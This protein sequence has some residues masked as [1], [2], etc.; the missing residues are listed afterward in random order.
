MIE[1]GK[2]Q[3]L[4]VL[5]VKEFGVY[6]G[7]HGSKEG[8]LLPRKQVPEGLKE[9]DTI[10]V[11]VYKD[12]R[13][14]IISTTTKPKAVLGELAVL[15]V[16]DT[17]RMG[18]FLDWGLEK[19]LLLPFREQTVPLHRGDRCLVAIYPDK[20]NRLC[21]TMKVY[22]KLSSSSPYAKGDQVKGTV[23]RINPEIGVFVAVDD[24]YYGLIPQREV[25]DN[26]RVGDSV[27]ARVTEVRQDGK[28]NLALRDEA[29]R[30]LDADGETILKAMEH[31]GGRLPFGEKVDPA[32]IKERLH[33]S[34][35]AFKRA[36]GHLLKE[37]RISIEDDCIRR[38]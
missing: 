23:Y 8:V 12:S 32:V 24:C 22:D 29:Y 25:Y 26:Y 9:G 10:E 1:L 15:T 18:A 38:L 21:A 13:D 36:L 19:D 14:R 31:C 4:E 27:S 28:L 5:R 7:E 6:L 20:S 17:A 2:I 35:N 30:Q 16:K 37:G 33:M 11:F 34:K 3:T